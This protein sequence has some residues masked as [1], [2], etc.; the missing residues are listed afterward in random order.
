MA[1]DPLW[2]DVVLALNC[3]AEPLVDRKGHVVVMGTLADVQVGGRFPP[4][5]TLP[6]TP[7]ME[8][9]A[10]L[11]QCSPDFM[12]GTGDF[13]IDFWVNAYGPYSQ[14]VAESGSR[15]TLIR[16]GWTAADGFGEDTDPLDEYALRILKTGH[17]QFTAS[18]DGVSNHVSVTSSATFDSYVGWTHLEIV[19]SGTTFTLYINGVSVGSATSSSPV[20]GKIGH[21]LQILNVNHNSG[22][23]GSFVL[24][25]DDIRITRAA[26]DTTD[27]TPPTSAF[28]GSAYV[29]PEP[30]P[31]PYAANVVVGMHFD[32]SPLV[33]FL[34]HEVANGLV[35]L[36]QPI[37][38]RFGN[39]AQ[40]ADGGAT[41]PR[42]LAHSDFALGS[43]DFTIDFWASTHLGVYCTFIRQASGPGLFDSFEFGYDPYVG[44]VLRMSSTGYGPAPDLEILTGA[45][46]AQD[47]L[48]HYEVVRDGSTVTIYMDGVS[49]GSGAFNLALNG[50][51]I[52]DIQLG[53]VGTPVI[54]ELRITKGI[55]RH[56][57]NFTPPDEPGSGWEMAMGVTGTAELTAPSAKTAGSSGGVG[58]MSAP[59]ATVVSTAFPSEIVNIATLYSPSAAVTSSATNVWAPS[60]SAHLTMPSPVVSAA[61]AGGSSL[62]SP[63]PK[64]YATGHDSTGENSLNYTMR[65]PTLE[66]HGGCNAR[67][68]LSK[69]TIIASMTAVIVG[70]AS[71]NAPAPITYGSQSTVGMADAELSIR[72]GGFNIIGYSGAVVSVTIGKSTVHATA[73]NGA[74]GRAAIEL[75]LFQLSSGGHT[76]NF[77]SAELIMPSA[78]LGRQLQA[79]ITAPRAV[80]TAIGTAVVT[81]TYEAYALNLLHDNPNTNEEPISEMTRYTNFPFTHVVRYKNSYYGANSTGLYLLEGTTDNG[82]A[83]PFEVKT[84]ETDFGKS[85]RKTVES[86]YLAGRIGGAETVTLYAREETTHAMNFTTPRNTTPQNHRQKFPR[87]VKARY[88][89]L[90]ISGSKEFELDAVELSVGTITRRI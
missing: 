48:T 71:L 63:S 12:F 1:V 14:G 8:L 46:P 25:I 27:F 87:G 19:R 36:K 6:P 41:G 23:Q 21:G 74:V 11:V 52:N 45:A 64:F 24:A 16:K 49:I 66:S 17:L 65:A 76:D 28:T 5:M 61:S 32:V 88:F 30:T 15:C 62:Y 59:A 79:W 58:S 75:P 68:T 10:A 51:G 43:G 67:L 4:S 35:S 54:D 20:N 90:G 37:D 44:I 13:T 55:A 70:S 34:G 72:T 38:S 18:E 2:N 80:L 3:D 22:V 78:E 73:I 9:H 31:D 47:C 7:A 33:D 56:T 89:A 53:P 82:T 69:P 39:A 86:A 83:I 81:A 60:A 84:A 85:E 57:S 26:R 77:G 42:L 50:S 29:P 40:F